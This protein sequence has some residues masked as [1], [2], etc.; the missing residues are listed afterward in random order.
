MTRNIYESQGVRHYL[1]ADPSN[2]QRDAHAL[3]AAGRFAAA[4]RQGSALQIEVTDNCYITIELDGLFD[5]S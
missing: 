4:R 5:S 2:Q 1:L 3:T